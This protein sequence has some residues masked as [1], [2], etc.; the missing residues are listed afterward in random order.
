MSGRRRS[1]FALAAWAI[2]A[3]P[4]LAEELT[5]KQLEFFEAKIRPV[6]VQQCYSCHSAKAKSV[7]GGLWVDSRDG[8]RTGGE[9]GA[10]V[11]PGKVDESLLIDALRHESFEMP[12]SGK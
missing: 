7:K 12:P 3:G 5:P 2:L 8:L 11:V 6:L 1:L 9:S 10:A 4:A